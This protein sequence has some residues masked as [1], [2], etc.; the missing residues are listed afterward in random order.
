ML[1]NS[2]SCRPRASASAAR[3]RPRLW[4]ASV[5]RVS[6]LRFSRARHPKWKATKATKATMISAGHM[7]EKSESG[8][9]KISNGQPPTSHLQ[10]PTSDLHWA[11]EVGGWRWDVSGSRSLH[12]P[13]AHAAHSVEMLCG[14]A[15]LFPQ[16]T[17]VRVHGAGVNRRVVFPH[18]AQQHVE[19]VDATCALC[20][21]GPGL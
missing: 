8:D 6:I 19:G 1:S 18:I 14:R 3:S 20:D 13:V 17:H 10:R 4:A 15:E 2:A 21:Q 5:R 11:L 12:K 16:A 9:W 7:G